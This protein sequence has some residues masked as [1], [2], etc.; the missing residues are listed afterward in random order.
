[1]PIDEQRQY[2][3]AMGIQTWVRRSELLEEPQVAPD[4]RRRSEVSSVPETII[5]R[6]EPAS[7]SLPAGDDSG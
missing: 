7:V 4:D 2:L 5:E 1:M 3:R 6:T